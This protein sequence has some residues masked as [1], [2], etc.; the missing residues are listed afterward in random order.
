MAAT[1]GWV[2]VVDDRVPAYDRSAGALTMFEYLRLLSANHKVVFKPADGVARQPYAA[3]LGQLGIELE[4][5]RVEIGQWL[6]DRSPCLRAALLSRPDIASAFLDPIRRAT[7]APIAYYVHDLHHVRERRRYEAT[8]DRAAL[9]ASER[10]RDQE[11]ALFGSVDMVVTP[12]PD[13]APEIVRLVAGARVSVVPAYVCRS[14]AGPHKPMHERSDVIFVGGFGHAPNI[15]AATLLVNEVMPLVWARKPAARLWLV[16]SHPTA[17]VLRLGS[18]RVAVTGFVPTLKPY[19]DMA[20]ASISPLRYGAGVK[21][22]IIASLQEGVPVVTTSI[23]N[24]GI[25]LSPGVEALIADQPD[26]LAE[27]TVR[28]LDDADLA[29]SIGEAGRR[30]C[31][32]DYAEDRVRVALYEALGLTPTTATSGSPR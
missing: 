24:E 6:R 22:K 3:Q 9:I 21:G 32:R 26:G 28:L 14:S 5:G 2:L 30:L 23:G 17:N 25:G 12:S 4:L 18:E 19:F 11:A 15:D 27:A 20:R 8:G 29:S 10:M 16:G 1:G 31:E 7:R 13:E